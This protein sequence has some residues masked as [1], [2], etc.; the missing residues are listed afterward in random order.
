MPQYV[1]VDGS[2]VMHWRDEQPDL[3]P[4]RNLISVLRDQGRTPLVWFDANAGYLLSGRYRNERSLARSLGL[5]SDHVQ[6]APK[7]TPADPLLLDAATQLDVQIVT[8]DR[9]RDWVE[10]YPILRNRDLLIKGSWSDG[11]IRLKMQGRPSVQKAA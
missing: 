7:G 6:V 10:A 3:V 4:V 8:N 9:Y 11:K 2:N 1:L 5:S